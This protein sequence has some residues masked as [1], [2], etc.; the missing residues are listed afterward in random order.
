MVQ[1]PTVAC[2]D[3]SASLACGHCQVKHRPGPSDFTSVSGF[4]LNVNNMKREEKLEQL[5]YQ[6]ADSTANFFCLQ[7]TWQTCM[8]SPHHQLTFTPQSLT[9]NKIFYKD[10]GQ[11]PSPGLA[12]VLNN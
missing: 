8:T 9:L 7:E 3:R 10:I 11:S 4:S 6:L 5:C 2:K 12:Q 1:V